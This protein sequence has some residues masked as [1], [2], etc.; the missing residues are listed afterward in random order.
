MPKIKDIKILVNYLN[1]PKLEEMSIFKRLDKERE[2]LQNN[3]CKII[4]EYCLISNYGYIVLFNEKYY[5][6]R[7]WNNV[8]GVNYGK[9]D[10][11]LLRDK[12]NE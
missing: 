11:H 10:A 6:I 2:I 4:K 7:K 12:N 9:W 8:Y 5:D 1:N 3:G